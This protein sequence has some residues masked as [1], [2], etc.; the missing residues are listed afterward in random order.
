MPWRKSKTAM[1]YRQH[2]ILFLLLTSTPWC[3]INLFRHF[4][5]SDLLGVIT[6]SCWAW[7]LMK[8]MNLAFFLSYTIIISP[9]YATICFSL[10]LIQCSWTLNLI[11]SSLGLTQPTATIHLIFQRM[12]DATTRHA[13]PFLN[14]MSFIFVSSFWW[15]SLS[16]P[17]DSRLLQKKPSS[18]PSL[19]LLLG[20]PIQA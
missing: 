12:G 18:L 5:P 15:R 20:E 11:K 1:T 13:S 6:C 17:V 4:V 2:P 16:L 8:M 3:L 9:F 7:F 19:N 10:L 14:F